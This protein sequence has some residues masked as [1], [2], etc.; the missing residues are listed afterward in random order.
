MVLFDPERRWMPRAICNWDDDKQIFFAPGG[1]PDRAPSKVTEARWAQAKEICD[2]CPVLKECRRDTLGEEF[3]VFG[4]Y[5]EHER[6]QIRRALPK[7]AKNWPPERR[8][9]WGKLFTALRAGGITFRQISLQTGFSGPLAAVLV[10]EWQEHATKQAS[11]V[12]ELPVPLAERKKTA[13][14]DKP[15]RRHAWVRHRGGVSDAYYRGETPDGAWILAQTWAGHGNVR[16]WFQA[17]D[18]H[19]YYPQPVVIL[20][21][22]EEQPRA[23][24]PDTPAPEPLIA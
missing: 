6:Y 12:A 16:K 19:L 20:H 9:A 8:L 2:V 13:F 24:E 4:G 10:E 7:A 22:R 5:D 23:R 18:V 1:Q 17:E 11:A 21:R 15:G 14:P 3:G